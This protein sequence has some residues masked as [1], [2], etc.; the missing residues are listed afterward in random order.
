LSA[1]GFFTVVI[2]DRPEFASQERFPTA[3]RLVVPSSFDDVVPSLEIDEESYVVI[4]TRGHA[5]D[6]NVLRQVLRTPAVYIGMIGSKTKVAG[7]F[8]T[9]REEGFTSAD[10]E[11]VHAPIGL[12]IGAETPEEIAIS[13]AAQ[14]IQVRAG[15]NR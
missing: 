4:V 7:A 5:H 2:D 15:K 11:R 13:I 8:Q 12:S 9:L 14:L 1:L 3:D 6:T 10:L